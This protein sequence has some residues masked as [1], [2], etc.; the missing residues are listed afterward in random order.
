M[1]VEV[2]RRD[3]AKVLFVREEDTP[4]VLGSMEL[5]DPCSQLV[6]VR[7][8]ADLDGHV[9]PHSN[10]A[11]KKLP[12]YGRVVVTRSILVKVHSIAV[13]CAQVPLALAVEVQGDSDLVELFAVPPRSLVVDL[14]EGSRS[15]TELAE[16]KAE[17]TP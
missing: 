10:G 13:S 15:P 7:R 16:C 11:D 2:T 17:E 6:T 12:E 14:E 5:S 9:D 4:D 3:I 8:R 1:V